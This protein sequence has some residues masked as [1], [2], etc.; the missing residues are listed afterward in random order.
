MIDLSGSKLHL[1]FLI[2]ILTGATHWLFNW[3]ETPI[4]P[5]FVLCGPPWPVPRY[6]SL[7]SVALLLV[8][9]IAASLLFWTDNDCSPEQ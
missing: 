8:L 3:L 5:H 6:L 7:L 2:Q 9:P 1:A 4:Y